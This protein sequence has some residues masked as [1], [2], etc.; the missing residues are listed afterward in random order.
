MLNDAERRARKFAEMRERQK[1]GTVLASRWRSRPAAE[2]LPIEML[3]VKDVMR[4]LK[5]S[6]QTVIRQ[7]ASKAVKVPGR[8]GRSKILLI[9]PTAIQEWIQEHTGC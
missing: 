1:R 2:P 4:I 9:P 6:R 7:F 3:R 5:V 8:T